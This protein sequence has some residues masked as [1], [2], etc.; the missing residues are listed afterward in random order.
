M[1]DPT[2][3]TIDTSLEVCLQY[4]PDELCGVCLQALDT[5]S[6]DGQQMVI[7]QTKVCSDKHHFHRVCLMAW[8]CSSTPHLNVCP[9]DRNVLFGTERVPQRPS[10]LPTFVSFPGHDVEGHEAFYANHPLENE[11]SDFE[12][13]EEELRSTHEM[14]QTL[15]LAREHGSISRPEHRREVPQ[16]REYLNDDLVSFFNDEESN[17]LTSLAPEIDREDPT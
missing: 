9:M 10:N 15:L 4:Q 6:S 17:S 13:L 3:L 5:K 2:T 8:F 12:A 1:A 7:V 11:T 14:F 16:E